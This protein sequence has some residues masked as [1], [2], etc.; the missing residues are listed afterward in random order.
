MNGYAA[1]NGLE[2]YYEV[3]GTGRPLVL[4][5]GGLSAIGT[6]FGEVLPLLAKSRQVIAVELQGHGRT[7]D[8]DRPL[9]YDL[10][11]GD[12]IA[13]LRQLGVESADFFGYSVGAGVAIEVALQAPD[14]VGKLVL[15]SINYK[16]EGLHPGMLEG[17]EMLTPELMVG[18]PFEEEYLRTAPDPEQWPALLEKVKDIDRE[19]HGWPAEVIQSIAAPVLVVIGDSDIVRP[20]HAVEI[21]R[22]FGGGIMGDGPAGL[23]A[24]Q[25][26]VLPGTSHIGIASRAEWLGSMIGAFLDR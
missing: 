7:A 26:A 25:L 19:F 21:F 17:I 2:M 6:S 1:V 16:P 12:T 13:L 9:R 3:H 5:H 11:A 4:L 23:P 22:L 10:L 15:A 20:E 24:S 8:I 18:T 14:L